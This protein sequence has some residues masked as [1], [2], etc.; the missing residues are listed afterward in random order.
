MN[1]CDAVVVEVAGS[2]AWVE[3]PARAPACGNCR[4]SEA[5]NEGLLGASTKPRRY[6]LENTIGARVGD[7]VRLAVADGTL[8]RASLASYVLPLV[9]AIGGAVAGQAL[10]GDVW[11]VGGTLCGLACGLFLLRRREMRAR[12]D[13][14]L[15]S[16]R[17]R[18]TEVRLKEQA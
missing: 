13:P 15:F 14:A 8:W 11:A 12:K 5:C 18:T 10:A 9:L 16:L 2:E 4:N 1:E 6:R 3:L 7:P 17:F